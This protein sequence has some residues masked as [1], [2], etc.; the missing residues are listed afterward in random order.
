[1]LGFLKRG[2]RRKAPE[3]RRLELPAFDWRRVARAAAAV[4]AVGG[5][6]GLLSLGLDQ[7][8]KRVLLEGSFQRVSPVEVEQVVRRA[9]DGGFLTADLDRLRG[10]IEALA[11]VDRARVQ[12]RWPD[13]VA[14]EVV[15]Q[16]PAARWG[17]DGLLNTRG[18]LFVS[19]ARHLP[20]EL[21]RLDG[22][23]GS[24]VVVAQ[25]YLAVQERLLEQGLRLAAL[26]LDPRGAWEMVLTNGVTVRLGRRD[27][28]A[29]MERFVRVAAEV[30]A[31]RA[32]DIDHVDMRYSNGFSIGWHAGAGSRDP[33]AAGAR[34]TAQEA[35]TD[36]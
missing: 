18:E 29:R 14:V 34:A 24:E 22:P 28:D 25:R 36:A 23:P 12:R 21:P 20:P 30:I 19:G 7:P 31:G 27:V 26:R 17:E 2:N 16:I 15:E 35:D 11:W 13:A 1:M 32:A 33:R 3:G 8:V 9:I 5:L 6:A 4:A 10:G